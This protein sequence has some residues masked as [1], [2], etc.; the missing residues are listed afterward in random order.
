MVY[1]TINSRKD[2]KLEFSMRD[3]GGYVWIETPRIRERQQICYG[4]GINGG[5]T[6]VASPS[7]FE[8]ECRKWQRQR[9]KAE[10]A[11]GI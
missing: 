9:L 3:E 6:V 8:A 5:T 1:F 10:R 4:G 7:T 2:G 11:Y